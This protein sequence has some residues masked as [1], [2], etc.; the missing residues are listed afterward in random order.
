LADHFNNHALFVSGTVIPNV[1]DLSLAALPVKISTPDKT[2]CDKTS[3][4]PSG[5]PMNS[6]RWLVGFL[7]QRGTGEKAGQVITTGSYAG[8]VEAPIGVPLKV[9]LGGVGSFSV[10]LS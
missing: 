4:H 3:P 6:I 1:F 5:G 9:E 10:K 2:L 8:I 7:N